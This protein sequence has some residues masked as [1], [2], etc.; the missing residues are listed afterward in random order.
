MLHVSPKTINSLVSVSYRRIFKIGIR[1]INSIKAI[2]VTLLYAVIVMNIF[3]NNHVD[4]SHDLN[5]KKGRDATSPFLFYTLSV[6][7]LV[8]GKGSLPSMK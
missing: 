4:G 6:A 3:N 5:H 8:T 1:K 7:G 2:C